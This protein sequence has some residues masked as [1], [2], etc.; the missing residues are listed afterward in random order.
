MNHS[1][2]KRNHKSMKNYWR[3]LLSL[4]LCAALILGMQPVQNSALAASTYSGA[5][6]TV[7]ISAAR[8][9]YSDGNSDNPGD[10]GS[11]GEKQS[12]SATSTKLTFS[13]PNKPAT[14]RCMMAYVPFS[15]SVTVPAYT[16]RTCNMSFSLD[17][18]ASTGSQA[19][20]FAELLKGGVPSRFNN[21]QNADYGENTVL[22]IYSGSS[23]PSANGSAV[24]T[25]TYENHTAS[26]VTK[27][28]NFVF[29]CGN[30]KVGLYQ[31]KP[32]YN[33]EL[34]G[35]TYDDA[36]DTKTVSF[37]AN[38]G[39]VD[40]ANK[41]VTY[42]DKYGDLPTPARTGYT[43]AGWYTAA[44]G[45]TQVTSATTVAVN[46]GSTL[47]A[48]WTADDYT[49]TFD[50]NGGDTPSQASKTVTYDS[51]YGTLATVSRTG[52]TFAGWYTAASGGTQVTNTTT[53]GT[54]K[55]HTIYAHWTANSYTVSFDKNGGDTPSQASKTVTYDSTYG[56]LA[57]VSRTGYTFAGWYTEKEGGTRV[58]DATKVTTA[59]SH[60]IYAHW[61]PNTYT[62]TFSGAVSGSGSTDYTYVQS[63]T[64]PFPQAV[65]QTGS[66]KYF[67]GWKLTTSPATKPTVNG[68]AVNTSALYQPGQALAFNGGALGNMTFTA[69]Y[70]SLTGTSSTSEMLTISGKSSIPA[71]PAKVTYTVKVTGND[72]LKALTIGGVTVTRNGTED[73][74]LTTTGNGSKSVVIEG[75]DA[76]SVTANGTLTVTYKTLTVTVNANKAVTLQGGPALTRSGPVGGV[77]T[78]SYTARD[79]GSSSF[80]VLVD[81]AET[82]KTV[83]YGNKTALTYYTATAAITTQSGASVSSVEL[84][85]GSKTL[86]MSTSDS[87]QYT[88]TGLNDGTTYTLRVNGTSV[89][90]QTT[91][92]SANKTLSATIYTR[93]VTTK[94][95]GESA[96]I[97]GVGDV[98]IGGLSAAQ[99]GVGTYL[100]TKV[101]TSI[102]STVSI[103]GSSVTAASGVVDYYTVT[104]D[105][106]G[107]SSA[108]VDSN[109]YLKGTKAAVLGQGGMVKAGCSFLGWKNG[110][111]N[112]GVGEMV[113]V[114][115]KT[116]LTAWWQE[117]ASCEV[118]WQ[119]PGGE[120]QYGTLVEAL[121]AAGTA[122]DVTITVQEGRTAS[123]PV[124]H[125]LPE[126]A[127]LI[128]P[129]GTKVVSDAGGAVLTAEGRIENA[130]SFD[131]SIGT[132]HI[133]ESGKLINTGTVLWNIMPNA[134]KIDN[135]G[136]TLGGKVEN[137]DDGTVEGGTITGTVTGGTVAGPLTDEGT[138]KDATITGPI[139]LPTGG[140]IIDSVVN[141][142]VLDKGG[143]LSYTEEHDGTGVVTPPGGSGTGSTLVQKLLDALGGAAVES[144]AGT[145]KLV[146][147]VNLSIDS[148]I[149][150]D[151]VVI[152]LN[153]HTIIGPEGK[154]AIQVGGGNVTIKDSSDPGKGLIIGGN[155]GE[156]E[157]GAPGIENKGNGTVTIEG[158]KVEGGS[159]G[160]DGDGGA[161]IKNTGDGDVVVIGG[162][163]SGG[164]GGFGEPGGKGG[165]GIENIG[166]GE[167]NIDGGKVEGGSG[168]DGGD[169][170]NGVT[171]TGDG[172]VEVTGGGVTGGTG[173][174]TG[175]GEGGQGG[176]GIDSDPD[177]AAVDPDISVSAGEGGVGGDGKVTLR[178]VTPTIDTIPDQDY[179]G[180]EIKPAVVVRD[181]ADVIPADEYVVEYKDNIHEGTATV[182]V[183]DKP[184]K[185]NALYKL[186]V[187][188]TTFV[189]R[190][191]PK[192]T[193]TPE[194][195]ETAAPS[196][197]PSP[198]PGTPTP[199]PGGTAAP[200]VKPSPQPG[201]PTP[202]PGGTAAPSVKPSPQ[203]G[204]PT[205][206][207]GGMAAPSA[208][209]GAA[210]SPYESG[211]TGNQI[212]KRK[213][214]SIFLVTGKQKDKNSMRLTWQKYKGASG[215]EI[216]WSYCDGKR[217][218]KKAGTVKAS[219]KRTFIHRK[220]KKDKAYKYYIAAYEMRGGKKEYIA[221]SPIIHVAM[222]YEKRTNVKRISVNKAQVTLK[223]RKSFQIKAELVLWDRK[224]KALSH[225]PA[226]RYYSSN[227]KVAAVNEK[228]KITAKGRGSCTVC[229]VA[230][231]GLI[232][233][234]KVKV[235]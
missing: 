62:I 95:D 206:E 157:P 172:T 106:N 83:S 133:T 100:A 142:T 148:L 69:Q 119:T 116:T 16:T 230:N 149:I 183:K 152:D 1:K 163:V 74:V 104:Y 197:K 189:I 162:E 159:G 153:G 23:D 41:T 232:K 3:Q 117:N 94:L 40:T 227:R 220:C 31:P 137:T 33:C 17:L 47:Y 199:E 209:P 190:G 92:F 126:S 185:E 168:N 110:S 54:A 28:E 97:P 213:D 7:D 173:G 193:P 125:I 132:L 58:T 191:E 71:P 222:K 164:D 46:A 72:S 115:D 129:A 218:F 204:T 43:F 235:K 174:R 198:Q 22:R 8:Y 223:R 147:D 144:P 202:E 196:A 158:G 6:I 136:G 210:D 80:P 52:Y 24:H 79:P 169:G 27:T 155:G 134:G 12:L 211:Q 207:P 53:V 84:V 234:I 29:F 87:N 205:P 25:V 107:G 68:T 66:G 13:T 35:I 89:S 113:A 50:K 51:T 82:G 67:T 124:D 166:D 18:S 216:Y 101:G 156:G 49:V 32:T 30:R 184:N 121:D 151:D 93:T 39:S 88:C 59:G 64:I 192:P 231:N 195:G 214:L 118:R 70:T 26:E 57:T 154:P 114:N 14:Q 226:L 19:G 131:A 105:T 78:Y 182:T 91:N 38:G 140:E 212:E 81:G 86:V 219:G 56:T 203:P 180:A 194:P 150:D 217:S 48:H 42:Y 60:T 5:A 98:K 4:V 165:S 179:T 11:T 130:G 45:G 135:T 187:I 34:T 9:Y 109:I 143:D 201:T 76:G 63:G 61:T 128:V 120:P 85:C 112:I 77:Y 90:G 176:K 233:K 170:G 178:S 127:K 181:G 171:N 215:Y 224:K 111:T 138:I 208:E 10:F 188:T 2:N 186:T 99:T 141:G 15:V 96:D 145:V 108:P 221:K 102:G 229:L 55:N 177:K 123:L 44:S 228:G 65:D 139:D 37:D 122:P 200:S 167:V 160:K 225:A 73:F 75:E 21:G 103:N 36:H 175:E 146:T 20:I 161:G